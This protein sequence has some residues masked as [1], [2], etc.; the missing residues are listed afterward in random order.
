MYRA[1]VKKQPSVCKTNRFFVLDPGINGHV[2]IC[3]TLVVFA[4]KDGQFVC[5]CTIIILPVGITYS[6]LFRT[7]LTEPLVRLFDFVV[8]CSLRLKKRTARETHNNKLLFKFK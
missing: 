1:Y 4:L 8:R 5:L 2:F 3:S 7:D 6:D